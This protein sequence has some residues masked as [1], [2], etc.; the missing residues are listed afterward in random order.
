MVGPETTVESPEV[1]VDA[2][3]AGSAVAVGVVAVEGA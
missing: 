3:G 1:D 2:D